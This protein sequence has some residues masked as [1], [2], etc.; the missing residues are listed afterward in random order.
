MARRRLELQVM[1]ANH[2]AQG[3]AVLFG[4]LTLRHHKGQPLETLWDAVS[5]SWSWVTQGSPWVRLR[6]RYGI[7]GFV[8][9]VE[10]TYGANGWHPHLH[11]LL[12]VPGDTTPDDVEALHGVAF[13]R[14][15]KAVTDRGL[16]APLYVGQD[17]HLIAGPADVH[18]SEY[19]SKSTDLGYELTNSQG[20]VGLSA[21]A[22]RPHWELLTDVLEDGD[23]DAADLWAEWERV[24]KGRRQMT[25]SHGL[26]DSF[27]LAKDVTDEQ[28]ASEAEGDEDLVLID[29]AGWSSLIARSALIPKV[30]DAAESGGVEGL[31]SFLNEH[32]VSHARVGV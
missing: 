14:W 8:R 17:L 30:L 6:E 10:V 1:V 13:A 5:Q 32:K 24:S 29:A 4:T 15:S 27:G 26:R 19:L 25:F 20:K 7:L 18:L 12:F 21:A 2:Q 31:C 11:Y 23:A 3:G 9:V 28:I 22:T 16:S